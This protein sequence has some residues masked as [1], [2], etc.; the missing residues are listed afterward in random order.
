MGKR[1]P[2]RLFAL[3]AVAV[4]LAVA[5][6]ASSTV[7]PTADGTTVR[8]GNAAYVL[9]LTEVARLRG[10]EASLVTVRATDPAS[11]AKAAPAGTVPVYTPAGS[12]PAPGVRRFGTPRVIVEAST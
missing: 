10:R 2:H 12:A 8:I 5:P 1:L 4:L 6:A 7:G 3:V 9:S 11:L